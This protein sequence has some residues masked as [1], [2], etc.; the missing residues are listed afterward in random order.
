MAQKKRISDEAF[1]WV[2]NTA[3]AQQK[4]VKSNIV[5]KAVASVKKNTRVAM[6][7]NPIASIAAV[8]SKPISAAA[9]ISAASEIAV[10]PANSIIKD[11]I[12]NKDTV[13]VLFDRKGAILSVAQVNQ[14]FLPESGFPYVTN[15]NTRVAELTIPVEFADK[16]IADVHSGCIVRDV[17][18]KLYLEKK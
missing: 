1:P 17:D 8:E 6:D 10:K 12:V 5:K 9:S 2:R 4:K 18:S 3:K 11:Q 16:T 15:N 13:F 7:E 14:K